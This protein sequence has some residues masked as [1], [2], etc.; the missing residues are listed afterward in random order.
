LEHHFWNHFPGRRWD[1]AHSGFRPLLSMT[2]IHNRKNDIIK[3][4]RRHRKIGQKRSHA[5]TFNGSSPGEN[6]HDIY[7]D[8]FCAMCAQRCELRGGSTR[9][10]GGALQGRKLEAI[11]RGLDPGS[12]SGVTNDRQS[13]VLRGA[14]PLMRWLSRR[15][16]RHYAGGT[17][18][19]HASFNSDLEKTP[20]R[21]SPGTN[22]GRE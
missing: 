14:V 12:E 1:S 16:R 21:D 22:R 7:L 20:G 19:P 2:R 13:R 11:F 5:D 18:T 10:L 4:D 6:V 8:V 17:A 9:W 3:P 15:T